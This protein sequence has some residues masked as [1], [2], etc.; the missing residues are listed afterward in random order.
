M[1]TGFRWNVGIK[2]RS[3]SSVK[4][5][6][7]HLAR[8]YAGGGWTILGAGAQRDENTPAG[9]QPDGTKYSQ[10]CSDSSLLYFPPLPSP[11]LLSPGCTSLP[12]EISTTFQDLRFIFLLCEFYPLLLEKFPAQII[13]HI[14][15][16]QHT[17]SY[18]DYFLAFPFC[19]RKY[20]MSWVPLQCLPVPYFRVSTSVQYL[21]RECAVVFVE[22]IND[23]VLADVDLS[24][25]LTSYFYFI[26]SFQCHFRSSSMERMQNY[27]F[28]HSICPW[29]AAFGSNNGLKSPKAW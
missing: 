11:S 24:L 3:R 13:T 1:E 28:T 19:V 8:G 14:C 6:Q 4:N 9:W 17:T 27:S 12:L 2:S 22:G 18:P 16:V 5:L 23:C 20:W 25:H 7:W 15:S 26:S 29:W 10:G 21:R